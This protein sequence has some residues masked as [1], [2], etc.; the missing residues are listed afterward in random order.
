M[1]RT[2]LLMIGSLILLAVTF[3]ALIG[4]GGSGRNP[5]EF[6]SSGGASLNRQPLM[7]YCAASNRAVMEAIRE[8]YE[9][10][11]ETP[12]E[13]QYGPSQTLISS[14]E[15]TGVGD[16]FLPADDSFLAIGREKSLI[17]ETVPISLM[18]AVVAIRKGNPKSIES[19]DDL[20]RD[21]VRLVLANPETAA[22]GKVVRQVLDAEDRWSPL[23]QAA[24]AYR[25]TVTEVASDLA[26]GAADAGIVYDAVL[27]T[28]PDLN[29]IELPEL[30][31]ASSR[32]A[33]GVIA[34]T[35]QPTAA[36][37]FARYVSSP[38]R[39][40]KQYEKHGFRTSGGDAWSDRPELSI[41][42]GSMLRPAIDETITE[43]EQREGVIV[44]RVYNG[45]GILVAQMKA[46]QHPD[47]Y[48]ACD[49]EFMNQVHDL[50]PHPIPVSQNELV[51][52]VPKGNPKNIASLKDLAREG[53]RVGIGHEKQC[54]M[55]WITQNTFR[56]GGVQTEIMPNV[57]VQTPTGDML[58]NQLQTGSLD[59][60]VAYL[61]NAAGASEFLDA[62]QIRGIECSVAT[63]PWAVSKD[64]RYPNLAGRLFERIR[65]MP[66]QEAFAAEGFRWQV[67]QAE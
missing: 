45:C 17:A 46:G 8:Q 53:L 29:Y 32:V 62:V 67:D 23:E 6:S 14:I 61:S 40:L 54:A 28:Y 22:V 63:Q 30:L 25:A 33:I 31:A 2:V 20:L 15:V 35:K 48:F 26:V 19:F 41:F 27:H 57:T 49:N 13:I 18:Q 47:A 21:D 43:F 66:S 42:A 65:S 39:G 58:V 1:N 9:R 11:Y 16:L 59:A 10:E 37:H 50:F 64:S 44:N 34:S 51:I 56:E 5:A 3:A 4:G 52:L 55:G 7:V 36:L 24:I 38:D 60:A 12:I